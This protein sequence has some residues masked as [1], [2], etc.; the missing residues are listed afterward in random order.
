M[1]SRRRGN[2]TPPTTAFLVVAATLLDLKAARLLP[3]GEVDDAEDLA[4]LEVRDLQVRIPLSRGTVRAVD[5]AAFTVG[6][7]ERVV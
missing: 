6:Q 4:L 1:P 3:A 2:G 7:G 5:G